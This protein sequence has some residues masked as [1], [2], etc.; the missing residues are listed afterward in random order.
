MRARVL[1]FSMAKTLDAAVEEAHQRMMEGY[2]TNGTPIPPK[3]DR[4]KN[5]QR[6]LSSGR[7]PRCLEKDTSTRHRFYTV[8]SEMHPGK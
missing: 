8:L 1:Y 2:A 3:I 6:N 7:R 5:L 4:L